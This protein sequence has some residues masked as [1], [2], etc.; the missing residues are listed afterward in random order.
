M[1][2]LSESGFGAMGLAMLIGLMGCSSDANGIFTGAGGQANADASAGATSASGGS[3][4]ATKVGSG[5]A[6]TGGVRASAGGAPGNGGSAGTNAGGSAGANTGGSAGANTGGSAG[7]NT[8]GSAGANTGG[9]GGASTDAGAGGNNADA[10][11]DG[12]GAAGSGNDVVTLNVDLSQNVRPISPLIYG[13]NPDGIACSNPSAR[14][15]LCRQGGN[16]WSTYNWENNASNA[17]DARCFENDDALGVSNVPGQTVT[18]LV[19]EAGAR[20]TLLTIPIIDYV[21]ADKN[22]GSGPPLC[23]GDVRDSGSN[24]LDTRFKSNRARKG[25]P[26]SVSPDTTDGFVYQDEFVNFVKAH[27]PTA[28]LLFAMDNQPELWS[29]THLE[30]HP[31]HTTFAEVVARNVEYASMVREQWPEAG[32]TGA[33]GYGYQAFTTLQFAP[34]GAGKPDFTSYYLAAMKKAADDAGKRLVDYLDVHWYSEA[35][36]GGVRVIAPDTTPPDPGIVAQRVQAPRS[37]WDSTYKENSWIS[38]DQLGGPI[39]LLHWFGQRILTYYPGTKLAFSSWSHGGDE[40]ISGAIAAADTLG[41]F[42]REGV[43]LAAIQ[44]T[45][46][47]TSFLIGAFAAYRNYDGAGATFGD[48][49]VAATTSDVARVAI[50]ASTDSATPDRVVLIVINRGAS[51]VATTLTIQQARS[52]SS[53]DVYQIT[54]LSA[55]PQ[56]ATGLVATGANVFAFDPPAYSISVIVPKP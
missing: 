52:F 31:A 3:G 56:P 6:N 19:D 24:Y 38:N 29:Y 37:L 48:T 44:A 53:A 5:G 22:G 13:V 18:S 54:G 39:D 49:S 50:Y 34:D 23:I 28:Q 17:G 25:A 11:A 41:I 43:A 8:G 30:A 16:P 21:A 1:R 12:G 47:D 55:L 7:A 4:G 42:G 9:S 14:F 35:S 45:A 20:A 36:A 40:H 10:G 27:A 32:I 46:T 33:V 2:R 15:T 51:A 26:L